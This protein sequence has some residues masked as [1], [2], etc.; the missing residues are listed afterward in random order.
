MPQTNNK[1]GGSSTPPSEQRK[2]N[3]PLFKKKVTERGQDQDKTKKKD[4]EKSEGT[5]EVYEDP[6]EVVRLV[7]EGRIQARKKD[8]S[9]TEK[10]KP[11]QVPAFTSLSG[12]VEWAL[13]GPQNKVLR[14]GVLKALNDD[15]VELDQVS[16]FFFFP[17]R[18]NRVFL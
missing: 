7:T 16:F 9:K 18:L 4:N 1:N 17:T 6:E 12:F 3:T 8:E 15:A 11:K 2:F 5:K 10:D 13:P 14:E